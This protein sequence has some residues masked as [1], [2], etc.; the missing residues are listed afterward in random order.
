[1]KFGSAGKALS[2]AER[3]A[4]EIS[5][6]FSKKGIRHAIVGGLAVVAHGYARATADVDLIVLDPSRVSGT[7]L[8]IPGV[9]FTRDGVPVDVMFIGQGEGFLRESVF[10]AEGHP[11][12]IEFPALVYLKLKAGRAKDYADVVE[13]LKADPAKV[14]PTRS[15]LR[16]H[17]PF[18]ILGRFES[19]VASAMSEGMKQE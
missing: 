6:E 12:V 9:T 7:P 19:A 18:W 2:E 15:W 8:G 10:E 14:S 11:P 4:A 13:L 5:E 3:V 16:Q 1:M 17:A